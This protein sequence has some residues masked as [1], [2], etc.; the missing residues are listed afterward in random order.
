MLLTDIALKRRTV[1]AVLVFLII[2]AGASSYVALPR[3]DAPDVPIPH[4]L[5]TTTY[6]GVSPEDIETSITI[7][8]EKE[9]AGLKGLKQLSSTSAEGISIIDAEFL[10]DIVI[11][12]ALQYV[13]DR[14]DLAKPELPP[15]A[16]E[17]SLKEINIAEFPIGLVNISGN[18]SP[19]RLKAIADELEDSIE[20]VPG[21]LNA[22]VLG[23]LER[24]IRIE[25][26]PDRLAS[27]DLTIPELLALVPSENVNVS[28]GGL[29]TEGTKFNVRVPAEFADPGEIN[30][31]VLAVRNDRPIYLANVATICDTFK[32]R[33]TFSR[34]DRV[35][36]ITISIQKR[37]GANVIHISDS[38]KEIVA[39]ARK[40]APAG[41]KFD[42]TFDKS[43]Y[44]RIMISDLE[45]NIACGL[46]L[47]LAVLLLFVGGRTSAIVAAAIPISMLM[48]FAVI[49]LLGYTL[50]MVVLFSLVLALGMLVDNAIVIVENIYR[51]VQLGYG[52]M[53]AALMGTREVAWPV[54]TSTATTVAA[55]FPMMFWPG[56]MGDFMKYLPITLIITLTSS[57]FVALVI[58][59]AIC[60]VA[61]G[62]RRKQKSD[63]AWLVRSYRRLL[64]LILGHWSTRVFT[65][66]LSACL[67]LAMGL[68]YKGFGKGVEFFPIPDPDRAIINI[69]S[70]QGTSLNESDR[71]ARIVE[72]RVE[73]YR[74]DLR[75]VITNV[76]SSGAG[77]SFGASAGG[78]HI[79]NLTLVFHDYADRKRSSADAVKEIRRDL[80]DIAGAE[81][82]VE[83]EK[84]GP[85]A[86]AP[87]TVRVIGKDFKVLEGLSE[88]A[89]Q[90]IATVP[91]LIDLRSDHEAA[92]P[93]LSFVPDR[94]RAKLLHVDTAVVG[95]FLKMAIFGMKV[96]VFRDYN[97]EY[98]I[99]VR[100]PLSKRI[101][102]EDLLSLQIPNATGKAVPL[103]SVGTFDYRGGFGT[104]N[105][106]D[107][108]RVVTLTADVEGRLSDDVLK[109][110]QGRL[111]R[112]EMPVGYN[113]QYAGEKEEMDKARAFLMKA[114]IYAVLLIVMILVAQFNSLT[115]PFIIMATVVLSLVGVLTGLLVCGLPFGVLMTGIGVISLAGVV[116]N[117]A[118]VLLDYTRQLEQRGLELVEAAVEAGKTR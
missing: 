29:E 116:V 91:G 109:D 6:E 97:D 56:I 42:I 103:S 25:I 79:A 102:V 16:D 5:I 110:V 46:I 31:L 14:I 73:K 7:K 47:V 67:L 70:P 62:G 81:I 113:L 13:R 77:F 3:E 98:D 15:E 27:Y 105:R 23:S 57:L 58:S 51:H 80:S 107:Q 76:G 4:V 54:A 68:L 17:P 39:E 45:N 64:E 2:V 43:K 99:T 48:S 49:S 21:V 11:E 94:R 87:I 44:I 72:E 52:R 114:F 32:D 112:L 20:Q 35:D 106:I 96:G 18:I 38:I 100:L 74:D 22:D 108:K 36:S 89:K 40:L 95:Q 71:L 28:A 30:G 34:L 12:D 69:R 85:P 1:V 50:N 86:G 10:S 84:V 78:P 88:K 75:Y 26:D 59:P 53:E 118:I 41:V 24:E 63:S 55:F 19:V 9:L 90:M 8:L 101:N 117:N 92:R 104:I 37:T 111:E 93:E 83:K 82:K 66:W 65:L 115:V 61:A 33:T 60:S